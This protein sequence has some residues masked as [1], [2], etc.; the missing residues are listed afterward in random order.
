MTRGFRRMVSWRRQPV[1]C[2]RSRACRSLQPL[3]T[4]FCSCMRPWGCA[5]G[6]C[7]WAPPA[8]ANLLCCALCRSAFGSFTSAFC[9]H[10]QLCNCRGSIITAGCCNA[11]QALSM[12]GALQ[13]VTAS[14]TWQ[15]TPQV[16]ARPSLLFNAALFCTL[17]WRFCTRLPA[18]SGHGRLLSCS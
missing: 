7:L 5:L 10:I 2:W 11:E 1:Q 17:A 16:H 6:P 4:R 3:C 18:Q 13:T 8:Q 14:C 9:R 15:G 12:T